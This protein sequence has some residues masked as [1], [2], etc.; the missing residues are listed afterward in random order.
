MGVGS[1]EPS[2]AQE[3]APLVPLLVADAAHRLQLRLV[4]VPLVPVAKLSPLEHILAPAV[5]GELVA[6]P[7]AESDRVRAFLQSPLKL[8]KAGIRFVLFTCLGVLL[9]SPEPLRRS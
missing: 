5:A 4:G 3:A 9:G 8:F 7:P 6:H 1:G 2:A